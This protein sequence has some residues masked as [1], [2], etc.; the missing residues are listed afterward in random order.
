MTVLTNCMICNHRW[1]LLVPGNP[2]LQ[3]AFCFPRHLAKSP[4]FLSSSLLSDALA[5]CFTEKNI[6]NQNKISAG[7]LLVHV[8]AYSH[9]YLLCSFKV[10]LY[11][12]FYPF[13]PPQD[14]APAKLLS[15]TSSVSLLYTRSFPSI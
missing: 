10:N 4:S 11:S 15:Y 14:I 1:P 9:L 13:C 2:I 5:S 3:S 6:S 12:V 7:Y 8:P